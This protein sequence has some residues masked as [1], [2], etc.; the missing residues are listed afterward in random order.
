ME[1]KKNHFTNFIT[2]FSSTNHIL[3]NLKAKNQIKLKKLLKRQSTFSNIIKDGN[4][5]Y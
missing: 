1:K 4:N 2:L 5:L 3:I